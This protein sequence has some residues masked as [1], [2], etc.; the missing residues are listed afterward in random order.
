MLTDK[1]ISEYPNYRKYIPKVTEQM[2][3]TVIE[4]VNMRV[5]SQV[6]IDLVMNRYK[7]IV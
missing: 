3:A 6:V 7:L 2:I 5:K 4:K 1:D